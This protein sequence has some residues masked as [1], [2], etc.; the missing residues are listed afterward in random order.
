MNGVRFY[1]VLTDKD[2]GKKYFRCSFY[3]SE[4]CTARFQAMKIDNDKG[5]ATDLKNATWHIHE[6]AT[7]E[8]MIL[9]AKLALKQEVLDSAINKR[10]KDIYFDFIL[11]YSKTLGEK[12][13]NLFEEKFPAY[14]RIKLTMWRWQK[15]ILPK[16]PDSQANLDILTEF[17][18]SD[19]GDHLVL[20]D[21]TDE[22]N[23]RILTIGDPST[24]KA[25]SE[26]ER[27]NIDCTYKSA[28]KPN[29]GFRYWKKCV[30]N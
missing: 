16:A 20:G 28:P 22:H 12:E 17:Y 27:L 4:N 26:S 8:D 1:C 10:R 3:H 29:W 30:I 6:N 21:T 14:K 19:G 24:L 13:K 2:T 11:K 9:K 5:E 15:E 18:F 23:N 25:F 7:T